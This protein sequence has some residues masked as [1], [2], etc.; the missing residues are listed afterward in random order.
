MF[1][2]DQASSFVKLY[3]VSK[4]RGGSWSAPQETNIPDS[5]S[6]Q[7]TGNLPN[8]KV[9]WIGNPT[10]NKS[11]RAL[12]IAFSEDGYLFDKAYLLAGPAN[13]PERRK[14]GL[15]KTIGYNYPKACVIGD[16]I[17]VSLSVNKEDVALIR[18]PFRQ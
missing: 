1:M 3:S 17:W 18:I 16:D 2:R 5:R 9:F 14:G 12:A 11:R 6:K 10:G 7:C 8:G 4:D 15:Y 13:L